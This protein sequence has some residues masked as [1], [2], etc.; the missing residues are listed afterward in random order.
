MGAAPWLTCWAMLSLCVVGCSANSHG[1]D[2][3]AENGDEDSATGRGRGDCPGDFRSPR[4]PGHLDV[5]LVVSND[6]LVEWFSSSLVDQVEDLVAELFSAGYANVRIGVTTGEIISHTVPFGTAEHG[7]GGKFLVRTASKGSYPM[8]NPLGERVVCTSD[9]E[10]KQK[11]PG[12]QWRCTSAADELVCPSGFPRSICRKSCDV[13]TDCLQGEED[14]WFEPVCKETSG[15]TGCYVEPPLQCPEAMIGYVDLDSD[16][17][18]DQVNL[19]QLRCAAMVEAHQGVLSKTQQLVRSALMSLDKTGLYA[20]Q[21]QAFL[22]DDADLLVVLV[23]AKNDCSAVAGKWVPGEA[24][25]RCH[26]TGSAGDPVESVPPHVWKLLDPTKEGKPENVPAENLFPLLPI[27]EAAS[28]LRAVKET[29]AGT[30]FVLAVA[31]WPSTCFGGEELAAAAFDFEPVCAPGELLDEEQQHAYY[32]RLQK[33]AK[34]EDLRC[35]TSIGACADHHFVGS[36]GTRLVE[37]AW[38]FEKQ[39]RVVS[40]C[41][42]DWFTDVGDWLQQR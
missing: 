32:D 13:D 11:L 8:G 16:W 28:Q 33:L 30:A 10:C 22:R 38:Q 36:L 24:N 15:G 3:I 31:G 39:G 26:L 40:I 27:Q 35:S 18:E 20:E 1:L 6:G 9:E 25:N 34:E 2:G 7:D 17:Q 14:L 21:A 19:G 12:A 23:S 4:V 37:F 29:G 5:V 42:R 41:R